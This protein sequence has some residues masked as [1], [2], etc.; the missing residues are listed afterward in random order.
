MNTGIDKGR[1]R[2]LRASG[3]SAAV[4]SGAAW[5]GGCARPDPAG[6]PPAA[7]APSERLRS[8]MDIR[9]RPV[10]DRQH[11]PDPVVI[12][13]IGVYRNGEHRFVRVTSADGAVGI[14]VGRPSNGRSLA[15]CKLV[16][17]KIG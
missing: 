6:I 5:L 17:S 13:R 10:L 3:M 11:L 12:E 1:R 9:A 4:L 15:S 14:G 16:P 7:Y 2:F 8:F